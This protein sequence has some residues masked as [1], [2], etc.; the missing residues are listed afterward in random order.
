MIHMAASP[1]EPAMI[2]TGDDTGLV[3]VRR[4]GESRTHELMNPVI[5]LAIGPPETPVAGR[6][7]AAHD[8]G[9]LT[10]IDEDGDRDL[11]TWYGDYGLSFSSDG[12]HLVAA[13]RDSLFM[14]KVWSTSDWRLVTEFEARFADSLFVTSEWIVTA[15]SSAGIFDLHT[16]A[17]VRDLPRAATDSEPM[18]SL[19]RERWLVQVKCHF[20]ELIVNTTAATPAAERPGPISPDG[21]T[22]V[23]IDGD[24]IT[25]FDLHDARPLHVIEDAEHLQALAWCGDDTLAILC[26][27]TLR[28]V[29]VPTGRGAIP[30]HPD[31][32][33]TT[34]SL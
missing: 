14:G 26:G 22:G 21:T 27:G 11:E 24:S 16:G 30:E 25:L 3:V 28:E 18:L 19:F 29:R 20:M 32:D 9:K 5:G 7:A 34:L 1:G 6:I 15:G 13:S 12:R 4:G 17:R 23:A 8:H 2:V 31:Y 10:L 33:L